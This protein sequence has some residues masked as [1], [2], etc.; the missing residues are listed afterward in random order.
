MGGPASVDEYIRGFPPDVAA[1]LESVRR[2]IRRALP[3]CEEV[4]SY[5]IAAF[6]VSG[7]NVVYLAGWKRHLSLYPIPPADAALLAEIA[8]YR[9]GKGTLR[10]P[11]AS[12]IPHD[13]VE[14]V[15]RALLAQRQQ[16]RGAGAERDAPSA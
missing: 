11:L 15:V 8:P 6:R 14:R 1:A 7:A 9:A 4:I 2:T 12:P 10:F 5:Q 13:L 16:G 3:G